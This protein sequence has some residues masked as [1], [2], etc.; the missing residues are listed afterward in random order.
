[1]FLLLIETVNLSTHDICFSWKKENISFE[2][3]GQSDSGIIF[4]KYNFFKRKFV[5]LRITNS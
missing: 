3:A 1:M 2:N 5:D 4:S